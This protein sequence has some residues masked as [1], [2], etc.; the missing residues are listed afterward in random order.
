LTDKSY[1]DYVL[2]FE[3]KVES[4]HHGVAVRAVP[5]EKMVAQNGAS[6]LDH[7][8]IKIRYPGSNSKEPTGTTHWLKNGALYTPPVKDLEFRPEVWQP[9]E[10]TV[11]KDTCTASIAGEQIVN[12]TLDANAGASTVVPGLQRASGRVG[13]QTNTGTIRLRKIEIKELS[14]GE[15]ARDLPS[16]MKKPDI[17]GEKIP[18][19]DRKA[20]ADGNKCYWRIVGGELLFGASELTN[21]WLFFGDPK[22]TDYDFECRAL[23]EDA[24]TSGVSLLFRAEGRTWNNAGMF[25]MGMGGNTYGGIEFNIGREFAVKQLNGIDLPVLRNVKGTLANDVWYTLKVEV[26]G[27][28]CRCFVDGEFRAAFDQIP[29]EHGCVGL[30]IARSIFRFR[31][32]CVKAPDGKTLWNGLPDLPPSPLPVP[33]QYSAAKSPP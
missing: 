19:Q 31:D 16:P 15:V 12:L 7:P 25:N 26:R 2:R 33:E 11:R 32:I 28:T 3:F 29:Y 9:M 18:A 22:W 23:R 24:G 27:S 30:R 13:F 17:S 5:G 21:S 20:V 4:G 10:V 6:I 1:S 14:A 8:I